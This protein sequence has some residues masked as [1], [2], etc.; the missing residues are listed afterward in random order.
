ME[1]KRVDHCPFCDPNIEETKFLESDNFLA[2][3]NIAP[4]LPGHSLIIPKEH[5]QSIMELSHSELCEMMVFSRDTVQVLLKAFGADA[6]N[7]T[8]QEGEEAGQT[9]SHLHLHLIPRTPKDLA[10]PGDWYPLLRKSES[11]AIDSD[12]RPRLSS[13]E[14]RETV[15]K[16]RKIATSM[17]R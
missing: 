16:I 7:W 6:F 4:I 1:K 5:L 14:M 3:Y 17:R 9:I 10:S 8:I 12:A 2:I 11:K 15:E 13:I